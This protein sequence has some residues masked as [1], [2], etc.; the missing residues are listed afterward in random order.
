MPQI[1]P[2]RGNTPGDDGC[3]K[4]ILQENGKSRPAMLVRTEPNNYSNKLGFFCPHLTSKASGWEFSPHPSGAGLCLNTPPCPSLHPPHSQ[5]RELVISGLFLKGAFWE[6]PAEKRREQNP[7]PP[8]AHETHAPNNDHKYLI[9]L[10]IRVFIY[11]FLVYLFL[12]RRN[13]DRKRSA[14]CVEDACAYLQMPRLFPP[15]PPLKKPP[16]INVQYRFLW[17]L[18][19]GDSRGTSQES[20]PNEI[21]AAGIKKKK[22]KTKRTIKRG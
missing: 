13:S 8:N 10:F 18:G 6:E 15:F 16:K 4:K 9:N 3:W 19:P 5:I 14:L 17:L 20:L 7:S 21:R 1:P 22:K 12:W 2:G 11:L